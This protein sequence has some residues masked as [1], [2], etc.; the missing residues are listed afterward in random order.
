MICGLAAAIT[1][2]DSADSSQTPQTS[3]ALQ[4]CITIINPY[5]DVDF[6]AFGQYKAGLHNHTA[7]SDG[8]ASVEEML[9]SAHE[10][11]YDIFAFTDHDVLF[12]R[13]HAERLTEEETFGMLILTDTVEHT[14]SVYND[15]INS[16]RSDYI[17]TA[18]EGDDLERLHEILAGVEESG[19]ISFINHPDR[20][21]YE[22][23][24]LDTDKYVDLFHTFDGLLGLEIINR[25]YDED[26]FNILLWDAVLS[27]TMPER[28]V[29]GFSNDDAHNIMHVGFSYNIML[30]PER[31]EDAVYAAMQSGAFYAVA[32]FEGDYELGVNNARTP[33]IAD[34]S[35]CEESHTITITAADYDEIIWIADGEPVASGEVFDVSVHLEEI[36]GYVRAELRNAAGVAYVQPFGIVLRV[37]EPEPEPQTEPL[38]TPA[39][40]PEPE[41]TSETDEPESSEPTSQKRGGTSV[42]VIIVAG[43]CAVGVSVTAVIRAAKIVRKS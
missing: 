36:G 13:R 2:A 39:T 41:P 10:Q 11:G 31:S 34:I 26:G 6:A 33:R 25:L 18:A 24:Y 8:R 16:Y 27:E 9:E 17:N 38:T 3:E 23:G 29:W 20:S 22:F 4:Y 42:I 37:L 35:V 30:L 32:R 40:S 19:G 5:A 1:V 28:A 43:I 15:H 12:A 14:R 21:V 7:R